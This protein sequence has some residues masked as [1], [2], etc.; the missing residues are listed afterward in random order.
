MSTANMVS[1]LAKALAMTK[2]KVNLLAQEYVDSGLC[3]TREEA[4]CY[5]MELEGLNYVDPCG[6]PHEQTAQANSVPFWKREEA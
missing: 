1:V 3:K 5:M 4:L 6:E 2:L